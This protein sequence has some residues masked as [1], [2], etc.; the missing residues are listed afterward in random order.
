V[1]RE[2]LGYTPSLDGLVVALA[3]DYIRRSNAIKEESSGKR[4]LM[5]YRYIN[6]RMEEAAAEI[7]GDRLATVF[8]E[9]IGEGVGYA[10]SRVDCMTEPQYK[11]RKLDVKLNIARKLHLLD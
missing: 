9:E 11:R 4:T 10:G 3:K 5:E 6:C 1:K 8:I 7:V 2:G